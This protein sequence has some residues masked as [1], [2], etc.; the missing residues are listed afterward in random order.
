[1]EAMAQSFPE[2][3]KGNEAF[4]AALTEQTAKLLRSSF[5][6]RSVLSIHS[7]SFI[8]VLTAIEQHAWTELALSGTFAEFVKRANELEEVERS[9]RRRR[10]DGE[11]EP[12]CSWA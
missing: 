11:D 10:E 3:L 5:E 7:I 9:A 1:M 6:V 12:A 2:H 8:A 4:F